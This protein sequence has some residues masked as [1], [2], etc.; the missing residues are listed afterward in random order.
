M[1]QLV[2]LCVQS[3]LGSVWVSLVDWLPSQFWVRSAE[4]FGSESISIRP[5]LT[6]STKVVPATATDIRPLSR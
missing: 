3:G 4:V 6:R 5:Q 1:E 2:A